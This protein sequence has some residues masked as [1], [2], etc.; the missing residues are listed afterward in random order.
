MLEAGVG[1][2]A[3]QRK[4]EDAA[5]GGTHGF[6]VPGADGAGEAENAVG[7]EGFGGTQDGAKVAGVLEAGED[8]QERGDV[9][10]AAKQVGPGPI[11]GLDEGG[12]G[13]RGFG[14]QG[15]IEQFSG[16]EENFGLRRQR[17]GFEQR[18]S[19]GLQRRKRCASP[20]GQ[21]LRAG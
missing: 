1:R 8:E 5:G 3:Q 19:P 15:R 6:G 2:D 18:S 16:D 7:A 20:R 21:P 9:A 4:P 10:P 13:L 14:G 12:N 11:R 17:E